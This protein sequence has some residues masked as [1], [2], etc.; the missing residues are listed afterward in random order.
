MG[1]LRSG[2]GYMVR[3]GARHFRGIA[4]VT[5][6]RRTLSTGYRV[7]FWTMCLMWC[8]AKATCEVVLLLDTIAITS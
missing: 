6:Q 4:F 1:R 5:G 7:L 3:A 2:G 8:C